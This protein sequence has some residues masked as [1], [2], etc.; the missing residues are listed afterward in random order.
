MTDQELPIDF[1]FK[2]PNG[3][4]LIV[5]REFLF[6]QFRLQLCKG[7]EFGIVRE[8]CTYQRPSAVMVKDLLLNSEDPEAALQDF[9]KPWTCE[10]PGLRIRLDSKP[11]DVVGPWPPWRDA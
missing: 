1:Q 9:A 8:C 11:E 2:H 4:H 7:D 5:V 3:K 10:G 6:G